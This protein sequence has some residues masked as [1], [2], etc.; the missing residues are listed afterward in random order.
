MQLIPCPNCG[1]REETEFHYG[2]AAGVEYPAHPEALDDAEWGDYLFFR[3]NP[4]GVLAERWYHGAGCRRWFSIDRDTRTYAFTSAPRPSGV[5][6]TTSEA[7][8]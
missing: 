6:S 7:S 3:P 1:P 4:K 2:A 5:T 8:Q